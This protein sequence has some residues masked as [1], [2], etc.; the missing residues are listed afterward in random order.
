MPEFSSTERE[1]IESLRGMMN[2][3]ETIEVYEL[4]KIDWP[5]P[6]GP[7]Y[8]AALQVDELSDPE[9]PVSPI[10]VRI[11]PEQMPSWFLPLDQSATIGDEEI[12]IQMWDGDGGFPIW[13]I[14][15]AR[16]LPS[17]R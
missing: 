11:I 10:D 5:S 17:S 1:K 8:Y 2:R 4:V 12:E 3:G 6:T 14:S 16:A 13:S 15:T 9:P 7:V